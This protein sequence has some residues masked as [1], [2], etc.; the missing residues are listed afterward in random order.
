[1]IVGLTGP[2]AAGKGEVAARLHGRGFA[3]HSLSDI[4]R[5]EAASRGLD[6]S[7]EHLIQ[8]GNELRR[9]G[10][11]GVLAERVLPRLGDRAVV[12][13]IRNPAEVVVLRRAAG[14]ILV[15][16]E[17]PARLRF[18]RT[19]ARARPGDPLTLAEFE[20]RERQENSADPEAQQLLATVRLADRVLVNEG[21][22]E[23]LHVKV[24]EI[25]GLR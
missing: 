1:M 16:V 23:A 7:R 13:S 21:T 14:F 4:V 9:R 20:E 11:A 2:N 10:G 22:I 5:D 25:V 19:V 15:A 12:D 8:V 3:V 6:P 24:D 17:A 18:A